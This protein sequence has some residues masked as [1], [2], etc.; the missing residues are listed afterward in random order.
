MLMAGWIKGK[1][2]NRENKQ[3]GST[4]KANKV[5]KESGAH[6]REEIQLQ[7]GTEKKKK[8]EPMSVVILLCKTISNLQKKQ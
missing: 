8:P 3:A 6:R 4:N 1:Q 7:N 2:E 5:H